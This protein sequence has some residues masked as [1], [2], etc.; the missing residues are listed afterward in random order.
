[1]TT[2]AT[3]KTGAS[4]MPRRH[5]MTNIAAGA[6]LGAMALSIG[7]TGASAQS[8]LEGKSTGMRNCV[9]TILN[10]QGMAAR[11]NVHGHDFI[12]SRMASKSTSRGNYRQIL[13]ERLR[14]GMDDAF[15]VNFR[16]N[17]RNAI[18]P[19]TLRI[20][21]T[22]GWS[23]ERLLADWKVSILATNSAMAYF[24]S[25]YYN[26]TRDHKGSFSYT[27]LTYDQ[28]AGLARTVP[29]FKTKTW[30]TAAFQVALLAIAEHGR[31]A[32]PRP[33]LTSRATQLKR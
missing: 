17:G 30:E 26:Q 16:V 18:V 4:R 1:M 29:A 3:G 22:N 6:L 9:Q 24:A 12:C 5:L 33:A 27:E 14:F 32:S 21:T 28:V 19:G 31:K 25:H 11:V 13:L 2:P 7:S 23:T 10:S 15:V 8:L 20:R